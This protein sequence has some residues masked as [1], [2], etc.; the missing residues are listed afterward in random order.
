MGEAGVPYAEKTV[1]PDKI[2]ISKSHLGLSRQKICEAQSQQQYFLL[3]GTDVFFG[4]Y[5][6]NSL[7]SWHLTL[8]VFPDEGF[9]INPI[10]KIYTFFLPILDGSDSILRPR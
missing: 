4:G 10:W 8:W 1:L 3:V 2:Y 5:T 7:S 6:F 9:G